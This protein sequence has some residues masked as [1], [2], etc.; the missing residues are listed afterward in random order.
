M[1]TS[2]Y[3]NTNIQCFIA[4]YSITTGTSTYYT[5]TSLNSFKRYNFLKVYQLSLPKIIAQSQK[6]GKKDG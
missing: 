1:I 4:Q 5:I 6:P 2:T 3:I